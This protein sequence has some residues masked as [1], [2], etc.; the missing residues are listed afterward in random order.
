[1]KSA[2]SE[3]D[4]AWSYICKLGQAYDHR[5]IIFCAFNVFLCVAF[6]GYIL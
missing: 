2:K 1:M 3:S 4:Y 5:I 6:F